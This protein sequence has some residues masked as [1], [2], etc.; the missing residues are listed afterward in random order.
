MTER[1]YRFQR[2][3][4]HEQRVEAVYEELSLSPL[5]EN[6][7]N[8]PMETMKD[9][10]VGILAQLK[11]TEFQRKIDEESRSYDVTWAQ[12]MLAVL[13]IGCLCINI[14]GTTG[15]DDW[16][17]QHLFSIRLWGVCFAA[18]FLGV[19]IERTSFF[20]VL[21][22]FG[23]TKLVTSVALSALI[24]FSTGKAS[25]ALNALFP[26]DASALPFT[27]AIVAGIFA[28][29]YAYPLMGV[30]G[31]F[32][33]VHGIHAAVWIKRRLTGQ[34]EYGSTPLMSMAFLVLSLVVF[35]YVSRWMSRDFSEDAMP[36][37]VY[38]LAHLLD[39][40][41]KYECVNLPKGRSVVFVGSDHTKVLFDGGSV[42]TNDI[43]TFVD[44]EK[45]RDIVIP[46][47]FY[48]V[49]CEVPRM[50]SAINLEKSVP[51]LQ[52]N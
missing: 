44:V 12:G 48:V 3:R 8:R 40:N 14:L 35:G 25:G 37:K 32:A 15:G 7:R 10:L 2:P 47:R 45:S 19:S 6:G 18:I 43:E 34:E 36:S 50:E 26:V 24:V 1:K 20:R 46:E 29:K 33:V 22:S 5:E 17:D 49:A 51:M 27:R 31:I 9:H 11:Q 52:N 41:A 21:W 16:L 4:D 23:V 28:F 42:E 38:R 30:V 13:A 39:F